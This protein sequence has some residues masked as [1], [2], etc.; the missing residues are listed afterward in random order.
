MGVRA[1]TPSSCAL[2]K[3]FSLTMLY[4][5]S[6]HR[7]F[8][9]KEELQD[10]LLENKYELRD[11]GAS[12]YN[13]EDDYP[14]ISAELGR[15]VSSDEI[16]K[17]ILLCGSGMGASAAVNKIK[18]IRGS[19]GFDENQTKAGRH[20][21]DINVLVIAT[22]YTSLEEAK[23]LVQAFLETNFDGET[24]RYRRR[25]EQIHNLER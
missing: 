8:K 25:I 17:G 12:S 3:R 6:D 1:F 23:K 9:L 18:G 22:D 2:F 15:L 20:D 4:I 10:W 5:G 19:V 21:D 14:L 13:K 16:N 24:E 7:G 11:V